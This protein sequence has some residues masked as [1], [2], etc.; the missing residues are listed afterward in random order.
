MVIFSYEK[1]EGK[2]KTTVKSFSAI[3]RH[4]IV[5]ISYIYKTP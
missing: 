1:N 3:K 5:D 2:K 4:I